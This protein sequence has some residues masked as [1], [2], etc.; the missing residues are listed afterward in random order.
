[1][2]LTNYEHA[3]FAVEKD[4]KVIV[5]DPGSLTTD[6]VVSHNIVAIIM[7]HAHSDHLDTDLISEIINKN[8]HAVIIGTEEV[9]TKLNIYETRTVHGGD[10]FAIEGFD[11]DFYGNTHAR[12]HKDLPKNQNVG[13]L[14][15]DRVYFPGDSFTMPGK[16]VEILAL[17]VA[18]PWMKAEEAI[19]FMIAVGARFT[20]PTHDTILSTSG[21][22]IADNTIGGF[23][24]VAGT[25][26]RRIDGE[27]IE[28][29]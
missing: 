10:G 23:S 24:E 6:F 13:V 15:E 17:P 22:T 19:D 16:D 1:M 11:L 2:K 29:D 12:I 7:T 20:F 14:I 18:G 4:R 25:D 28:I 9:T 5:I 3:C 27:T 26:Y 21:K 8:P